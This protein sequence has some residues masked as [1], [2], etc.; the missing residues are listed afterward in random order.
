MHDAA[1]GRGVAPRRPS[2]FTGPGQAPQALLVGTQPRGHRQL[3][4]LCFFTNLLS[5]G[6]DEK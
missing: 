6:P 2:L 1:G 4:T 3:T 5:V